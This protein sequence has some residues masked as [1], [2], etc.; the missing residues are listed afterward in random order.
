MNEQQPWQLYVLRCSDGTLYTGITTD[1]DRRVREHQ[2][3]RGARY[4]RGRRPVICVG[5]WSYPDRARAARSEHA[6][7]QLRRASKL[8]FIEQPGEWGV[9]ALLSGG[10]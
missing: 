9:G 8:H 5:T 1:L 2:D 10:V 4:T 7:K 3:G 6:F